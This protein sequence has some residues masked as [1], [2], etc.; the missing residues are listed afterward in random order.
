MKQIIEQYKD[1]RGRITK[2]SRVIDLERRLKKLRKRV[3]NLK[4]W[5]LLYFLLGLLVGR[6]L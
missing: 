2:R 6:A 5:V 3:N 4:W 1:K